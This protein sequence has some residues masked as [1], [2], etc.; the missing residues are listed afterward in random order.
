MPL[1]TLF[2][3]ASITAML[4]WLVLLISPWAPRFADRVSGIA[5]PLLLSI[6]YAVGVVAF[7][8]LGEGGFDTLDNVAKLFT[9]R[10]VVLVGWVHFL[11]FDL[12]VGAWEVRTARRDAIPFLLVV[13]CLVLTFLVGPLGLALFL[14]LRFAMR[15]KLFLEATS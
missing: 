4:G 14:A 13:P 8:G 2:Q 10:E 12:F 5:I 3:I 15:R 1:D 7:W 9:T 6:G 11:A